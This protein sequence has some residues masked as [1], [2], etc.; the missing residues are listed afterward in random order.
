MINFGT[1][2]VN[3]DNS[4]VDSAFSRTVLKLSTGASAILG[5]MNNGIPCLYTMKV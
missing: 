2:K 3:F 5:S 1:E 4:H